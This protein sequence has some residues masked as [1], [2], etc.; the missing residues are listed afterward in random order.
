MVVF[1]HFSL[2]FI[3]RTERCPVYG[4]GYDFPDRSSTQLRSLL[5]EWEGYYTFPAPKPIGV[6]F[7]LCCGVLHVVDSLS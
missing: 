7:N 3:G 1:V 6:C 2:D 4:L 5:G